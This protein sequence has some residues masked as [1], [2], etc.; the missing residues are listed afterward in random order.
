MGEEDRRA[1]LVGLM[2]PGQAPP[3]SGTGIFC[4]HDAFL[5]PMPH[6]LPQSVCLPVLG[7]CGARSWEGAC[8]G[9]RGGAPQRHPTEKEMLCTGTD[10]VDTGRV[11]CWASWAYSPGAPMTPRSSGFPP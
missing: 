3:A 10:R 8:R 2:G 7:L 4:A 1:V 6:A 9:R 11:C 5:L